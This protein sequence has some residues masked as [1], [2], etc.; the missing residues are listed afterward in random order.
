MTNIFIIYFY[1]HVDRNTLCALHHLNNMISWNNICWVTVV[2]LQLDYG[3]MIVNQQSCFRLYL[4]KFQ[5][6]GIYYIHISHIWN[7]N[8]NLTF[9]IA[10]MMFSGVTGLTITDLITFSDLWSL[11]FSPIF[12]CFE[13]LLLPRDATGS[14][15][16]ESVNNV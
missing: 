7:G 8:I 1:Q 9:N 5:W 13:P 16:S 11:I 2:M 4:Q 14:S 15:T 6:R 3:N 12:L 10:F